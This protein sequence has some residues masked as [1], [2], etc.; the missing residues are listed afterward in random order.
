[1][2]DLS[3]RPLDNGSSQIK[4]NQWRA[5]V[6]IHR[7][8]MFINRIYYS[9]KP[10]LPW[11]LRMALRRRRARLR[12]VSFVDTWPIDEKSGVAP[13]GW[14][15]WPSD[16]KFAF[17]LTHDVEGTRGLERV[18][19]LMEL[20]LKHGFRSSFNFVPE[21]EYRVPESVRQE[22]G[23]AGFEIGV[24]GL[25]HDGK[26]YNSKAKFAR[27]AARIRHYVEKWNASG[28]RSP[29]MQSRLEWLHEL[30]V[31]Y[32]SSTFDTDPFEPEP[33]GVG[34]VF[35]FWV[36]GAGTAGYVE[37]PSTLPQDFTLFAI[38]REN[39]IDIWKRKLN[40]I[41]AHGGMAL[42]NTHPDY[43]CF[44]G[45]PARGEFPV[46]HYEEI[47]SYVREQYQGQFWSAPPREVAQYC[48]A[49][50]RAFETPR[51]SVPY[52]ER[53]RWSPRDIYS[54]PIPQRST[55]SANTAL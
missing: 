15:G 1:V 5:R 24:H 38:L 19:Q 3:L 17:V 8:S 51:V 33:D 16:N 48:G 7:P 30:G 49:Y 44:E 53:P 35:P 18:R 11:H 42:L 41:A 23:G 47:L 39:N 20:D 46:A 50:L 10:I 45:K 34:T 9:L 13:P 4:L 28:F 21:G 2:N 25:E 27:K 31:E 36:P 22:L 54:P 52:G 29:F 37:L 43:M 12:R 6:K 55:K 26:L 40:W 32:D 14:P